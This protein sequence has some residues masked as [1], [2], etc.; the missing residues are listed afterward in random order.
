MHANVLQTNRDVFLRGSA[1][2]AAPVHSVKVNFLCLHTS[3]LAHCF[4][5][6]VVLDV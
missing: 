3:A 1:L 6:E 2:N 4:E 5:V